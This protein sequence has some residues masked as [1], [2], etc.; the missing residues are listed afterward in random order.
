[1]NYDTDNT[2]TATCREAKELANEIRQRVYVLYY[3]EEDEFDYTE[4]KPKGEDPNVTFMREVKPDPIQYDEGCN[5]LK[6]NTV[7]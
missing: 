7:R 1:M 2:L 3:I 6:Y 4:F 5:G